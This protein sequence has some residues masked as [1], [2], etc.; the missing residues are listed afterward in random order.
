MVSADGKVALGLTAQA[1]L[2]REMCVKL[3]N[4]SLMD[5]TRL[6]ATDFNKHVNL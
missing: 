4:N 6:A 1:P 3:I 2:I 5:T